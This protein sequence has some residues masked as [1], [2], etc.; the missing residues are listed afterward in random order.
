TAFEYG[1]KFGLNMDPVD[2]VLGVSI[3]SGVSTNP[4]QMAQAYST[5]ANEGIMEDAH[6]IS[7]IE[8]ANGVIIANHKANS[9]R[10]IDPSVADKMTSM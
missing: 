6:L 1:K 5:F 9:K 2:R 10:I 3:G 8:T 4:L 7:R